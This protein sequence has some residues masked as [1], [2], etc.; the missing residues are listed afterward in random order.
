[1][2]ALFHPFHFQALHF[3]DLEYF[4]GAGKRTVRLTL[5]VTQPQIPFSAIMYPDYKPLRN[6]IHLFWGTLLRISDS[7]FFLICVWE[8]KF[9]GH[10]SILTS[11]ISVSPRRTLSFMKT[12]ICSD[13]LAIHTASPFTL[14]TGSRLCWKLISLYSKHRAGGL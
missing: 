2:S 12:S 10:L 3:W 1:M 6:D 8:L 7:L 4:L 11:F 13:K 5:L 9:W 14:F